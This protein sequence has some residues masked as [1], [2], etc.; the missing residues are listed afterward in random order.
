MAQIQPVNYQPMRTRS[1]RDA[2]ISLIFVVSVI[3]LPTIPG[4]L[5]HRRFLWGNQVYVFG[6][7]VTLPYNV[8]GN[9]PVFANLA[10]RLVL[11]QADDGATELRYE[12]ADLGDFLV[13]GGYTSDALWT[14]FSPLRISV[15]VV[16]SAPMP[17]LRCDTIGQQQRVMY[18]VTEPNHLLHFRLD[19]GTTTQGGGTATFTAMRTLTT[20]HRGVLYD[21]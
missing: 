16:P 3:L 17:R 15:S 10:V 5:A 21:Y 1:R 4:T 18:F 9:L 6:S 11:V 19:V 14:P 12:C 20:D 2:I 8:T 7:P 13:S